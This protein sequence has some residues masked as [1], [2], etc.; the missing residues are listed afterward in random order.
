MVPQ[1]VED[2]DCCELLAP[3]R[4]VERPPQLRSGTGEFR[5]C[6]VM[7]T[8]G[9]TAY[10]LGSLFS[11]ATAGE[12][13]HI[14]TTATNGTLIGVVMHQLMLIDCL[15]SNWSEKIV[16]KRTGATRS[17]PLHCDHIRRSRR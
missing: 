2:N 13:R 4:R 11:F 17:S 15:A 5:G 14:A 9:G 10:C 8:C 12:R 16:E 7:I 1:P 6:L 3:F